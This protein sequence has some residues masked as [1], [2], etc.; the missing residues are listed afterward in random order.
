M[1]EDTITR[2]EFDAITK[3]LDN[4]EKSAKFGKAPK[5]TRKPSEFN[6]Y[7]GDKI[8]EIKGK[9]PNMEHKLAFKKAVESWNSRKK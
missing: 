7:V 1:T 3:R 2:K 8:K 5:K 4:L 9:N 6:I